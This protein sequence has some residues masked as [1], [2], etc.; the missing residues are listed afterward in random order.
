[1]STMFSPKIKDK[2]SEG[3][4]ADKKEEKDLFFRN[5]NSFCDA[6]LETNLQAVYNHI[7]KT[8]E[9]ST[10]PKMALFWKYAEKNDF[11]KKNPVKRNPIWNICLSCGCKYSWK[12]RGCPK[13]RSFRA[14]IGMGETLPNDLI[15]VQEDCFYCTIYPESVKKHNNKK[16]YFQSCGDFGRKQ[17]AACSACQCKECCRQM[18][19]Y[20]SDPK[21]TIEKYSTTE[22]AQPWLI[23]SPELSKTAQ[24]M[25]DHMTRNK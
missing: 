5:L 19:M 12:G 3:M 14:S 13:C 17:D 8:H 7:I 9:F 23:E 18:M 1:M 22:L 16:M 4:I 25:L 11:I 21:G 6:C 2:D 20:N 15:E 24:D 10:V